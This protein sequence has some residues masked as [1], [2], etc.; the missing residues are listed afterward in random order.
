MTIL[1]GPVGLRNG[2]EPV[3]NAGIDQGKVI[4]LLWSLDPTNGGT[5][6]ISPKPEI[7]TPP[8][9][10]AELVAAITA[11]QDFWVAKGEFRLA[12]GVVDPA[13]RTLRKLD[14]LPRGE[15]PPIPVDPG[16]TDLKVLSFQQTET[17]APA[18]RLSFPAVEPASVVPFLFGQG[19]STGATLT[20]GSAVGTISQFLFKLKKDGKI[21]WVG[22]A[23][24]EG[25]SDFSRA[26]IF[27]HPNTKGAE[28]YT[29]FSGGWPHVKRY[30][31][32]LGLQMASVKQMTLILPF[33]PFVSDASPTC[34]LFADR[35]V[36]TL[37]DILAAIQISLGQTGPLGSV[38]QIGVSSYSSGIALLYS[39]AQKMG[40]TG[41]IREQIDFDSA[42]IAKAHKNAPSLPDAV[43]WMV[44]QSAPSYANRL[45]WLHLPPKSFESVS[46]M[47]GDVHGQIGFLMF[48]SMMA[49]SVMG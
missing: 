17:I 25:T 32:A 9:C 10:S 49:F 13:G 19:F 39:F 23:V 4:S 46:T 11:F 7:L 48:K 28:G 22:A 42:Y 44:T 18:V 14:A 1:S 3:K 21:F 6:G 36:D 26:H 41:L 20:E 27:F 47:K 29:T 45:G 24:P 2:V 43:N 16:F 33:T 12:D 31:P 30:L 40:S 8:R 34:P 5:K 15:T 37:N 38:E 35:G